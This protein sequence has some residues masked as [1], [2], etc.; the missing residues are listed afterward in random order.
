M[1]V[2]I[3]VIVIVVV[4]EVVVV[5]VIFLNYTISFKALDDFWNLC[6]GDDVVCR[7]PEEFEGGRV[8]SD[9]SRAVFETSSRTLVGTFFRTLL[10]SRLDHPSKNDPFSIECL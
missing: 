5:V 7:R 9:V 3:V 8:W 2:I 6:C 10:G 1:L 4:V